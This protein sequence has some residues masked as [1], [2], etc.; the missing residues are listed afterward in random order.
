MA[1]KQEME[2]KH[3]ITSDVLK[4]ASKAADCASS[5][6]DEVTHNKLKHHYMP[7]ASDQNTACDSKSL[8]LSKPKVIKQ[9][10]AD[11][12]DNRRLVTKK[13]MSP[14][15]EYVQPDIKYTVESQ[16]GSLN[17][18]CKAENNLYSSLVA[19]H[20]EAY[21]EGLVHQPPLSSE[22]SYVATLPRKIPATN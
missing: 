15:D 5:K 4:S 10:A 18:G 11:A 13:S 1:R 20:H 12:R 17:E 19:P 7:S 14:E 8:S 22:Y 3:K 16:Y 21:Y 9:P 2:Q 6:S